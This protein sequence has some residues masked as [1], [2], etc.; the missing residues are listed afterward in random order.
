MQQNS[1]Q[2][3]SANSKNAKSVVSGFSLLGYVPLTA[4]K[5]RTDGDARTDENFLADLVENFLTDSLTDNAPL[6]LAV[7]GSDIL[8][9]SSGCP[10]LLDSSALKADELRR[11]AG[12]KQNRA[13]LFCIGR[14][15]VG[16]ADKAVLALTGGWE[17]V[18][19]FGTENLNLLGPDGEQQTPREIL[20]AR[21]EGHWTSAREYAEMVANS[22]DTALKQWL[23]LVSAAVAL[24]NWHS[25]AGFDPISGEQTYVAQAG[26]SRVTT[27]GRE[28]FPRTDPAVI[29]VV[30]ARIEGVEKILLGQAR[31]WQKK[32]FSTFA[33]FVEA[34]ESIENAVERELWEE[35]GAKV[36]TMQYMGSQPWPFPRS[37]MLGFRAEISNP[38]DVRAD[39]DEI[40]TVRWFSR[41]ELTAAAAS[42][43]IKLPSRASISRALIKDFLEE[44]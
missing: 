33:G 9:D 36:A 43:E 44:K 13:D 40:E 17:T 23:E 20:A 22:H 24:N 30:T 19:N 11:L 39:G 2:K 10:V 14:I 3:F 37:L 34:G 1:S 21:T 29:T 35:C 16:G 42:G 4:T 32:R 27:S 6:L 8:L 7:S 26:W 12:E 15:S 31:A 38:D 5:I 18:C 41:E 28:L 25:R